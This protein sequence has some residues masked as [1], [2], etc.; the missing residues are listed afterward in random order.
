MDGEHTTWLLGFACHLIGLIPSLGNQRSNSFYL[1]GNL[2]DSGG[3]LQKY[4]LMKRDNGDVVSFYV[5][6]MVYGPQPNQ[7]EFPKKR[8]Q[9]IEDAE[10]KKEQVDGDQQKKKRK[11]KKH[12]NSAQVSVVEW[13]ISVIF[14]LQIDAERS[15]RGVWRDQF[16]R[17]LAKP[18]LE[19]GVREK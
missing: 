9:P 8:P 17:R 13:R 11:S 14:W 16:G 2:Q 6:K 12:V 19:K 5:R 18:I 15:W 4:V 7:F 3:R 10:P 1:T